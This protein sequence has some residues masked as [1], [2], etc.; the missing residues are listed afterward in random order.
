[1][2]DPQVA[3]AAAD[4]SQ[5]NSQQI[6]IAAASQQQVGGQKAIQR[7]VPASSIAATLEARV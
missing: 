2:A 1:M 7:Q 6:A 4:A 5:A 3:A